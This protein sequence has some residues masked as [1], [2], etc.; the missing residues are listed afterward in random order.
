MAGRFPHYWT[1]V[2]II[3]MAII[4]T[5]SIIIWSRYDP[6]QPVEISL[7]DEE[8]LQGEIYVGG[9]VNTPGFYPLRKEDGIED[10]IQAAGGISDDADPD[11]IELLILNKEGIESAQKINI[12]LAEAWLLEALPGIGETRA[13]AIIDYRRRKGGFN[14]INELL[15]IE[16]IGAASFEKINSLITVAD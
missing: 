7:V 8:E 15:E 9:G 12:N 11:Q 6:N 10:L 5:G 16:G 1:L 4:V 3:L 14:N 13:Q 2:F